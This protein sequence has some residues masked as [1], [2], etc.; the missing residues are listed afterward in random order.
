MGAL[1]QCE[2]AITR[3][4]PSNPDDT[5]VFPPMSQALTL[6]QCLRTVTLE[7]AWQARMEDKLGSIEIGNYADLV[8]LEKNLFDVEPGEIADVKVVATMMD[9]RYTFQAHNEVSQGG[10]ESEDAQVASMSLPRLPCCGMPH[11]V[12]EQRGDAREGS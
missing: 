7:G 9:G 12:R 4:D 1:T 6:E 8:I 11:S 5:R 3:M 10:K 2:A